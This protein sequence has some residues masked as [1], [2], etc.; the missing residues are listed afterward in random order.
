MGGV[1]DPLGEGGGEAEGAVYRLWGEV[2]LLLQC[3][4]EYSF[5]GCFGGDV[6]LV[7]CGLQTAG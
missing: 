6:P 4:F 5:G 7:G 2:A 1:L 3:L